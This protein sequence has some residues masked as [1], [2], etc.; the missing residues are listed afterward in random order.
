MTRTDLGVDEVGGQIVTKT[1]TELNGIV[2]GSRAGLTLFDFYQKWE[3]AKQ[4]FYKE[5]GHHLT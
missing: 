4:A 2:D 3:S 5:M 1:R